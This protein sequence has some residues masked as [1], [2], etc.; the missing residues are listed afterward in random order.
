MGVFSLLGV[1]ILDLC[2]TWTMDMVIQGQNF[3]V[4]SIDHAGILP[5][6]TAQAWRLKKRRN[7]LAFF[8]I[9]PLKKTQ[10]QINPKKTHQ[11]PQTLLRL[12]LNI[13]IDVI[14][15]STVPS[16][17]WLMPLASFMCLLSD[18]SVS[19][20]IP[21]LLLARVGDITRSVQAENGFIC[22]VSQPLL[23]LLV[24]E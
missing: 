13:H 24:H 15:T 18:S 2:I 5:Q 23:N 7:I 14:I 4:S 11:K 19:A 1:F 21:K 9:Y 6:W 12:S 22:P 8:K 16:W 20:L 10:Q 3:S 17:I